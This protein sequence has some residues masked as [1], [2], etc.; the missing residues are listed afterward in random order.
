MTLRQSKHERDRVTKSGMGIRSDDIV[1]FPQHSV[2]AEGDMLIWNS[3]GAP[4]GRGYW[5]GTQ[6]FFGTDICKNYLRILDVSN[7]LAIVDAKIDTTAQ[8]IKNEIIGQAP[9][10]LDTLKEIADALGDPDNIAGNV[11][12]KLVNHDSQIL[13]LQAGKNITDVSVNMLHQQQL[14]HTN[15][16]A[17]LDQTVQNNQ[18]T[19]GN[20]IQLIDNQVTVNTTTV[21]AVQATTTT[22]QLLN[23]Q[24]VSQITDNSNNILN[25]ATN[26]TTNANNITLNDQH[27][28][29]ADLSFNTIFSQNTQRITDICGNLSRILSNDTDIA[30][31]QTTSSGNTTAINNSNI[32]INSNTLNITSNDSDINALSVRMNTAEGS[33]ITHTNLINTNLNTGNTNGG[34]ITTLTNLTT[35]HTNKIAILDASMARVDAIIEPK[36]NSNLAKINTNINTIATNATNI[37]NNSTNITNNTTSI[38]TN[39]NT[40]D[41][42]MNGTGAVGVL[43]TIKELADTIGDPNGIGSSVIT[44]LSQLDTSVTTLQN[45]KGSNDTDIATNATN[46]SSNL[47]LINTKE[48][49]ITNESLAM[50]KIQGLTTALNSKQATI[51]VN[52]LPQANVNGLILALTNKQD[53]I[54]DGGLSIVK[55]ANLETSLAA[56]Q[57]VILDNSLPQSKVFNLVASLGGKQPTVGP[58]DLLVSHVQGLQGLLDGKQ[59]LLVNESL[60][61][62]TITGLPGALAQKQTSLTAGSKITL[63]NTG[64]IDTVAATHLDELLDVKTGRNNAEFSN[65][66]LIGTTTTGTLLGAT[67][68]IGIG[69]LSLSTIN[70]GKNNTGIGINTLKTTT[71]KENCVAIGN[72]ALQHVNA[73]G[74]VAVGYQS[75]QN[76]LSGINNTFIGT[77]TDVTATYTN[78]NNATAIGY[79]AKVT[80]SNTVKLGNST[81]THVKTDGKYTAGAVTYTNVDGTTGQFLKTDGNGNTSWVG[82]PLVET[83]ANLD[84]SMNIVR[85]QADINT[86]NITTNT[87]AIAALVNADTS[88]LALITDISNS[89]NND[90]NFSATILAAITNKIDKTA[91]ATID[92]VKSFTSPI[93]GSL[94]GNATTATGFLTQTT[95]NGKAYHGQGNIILTAGDLG[96][97]YNNVATINSN[98]RARI[99][100]IESLATVEARKRSNVKA[101]GALM[102]DLSE[103]QDVTGVKKFVDGIEIPAGKQLTGHCS[104]ATVLTPGANINGHLFTGGDAITL[105]ATDLTGI[106]HAGSGAIITAAERTSYN[107]AVTR[108]DDLLDDNG[109]ILDS[110]TEISTALNNNP[111]FATTITNLANT[112]MAK[113][114]NVAESITGVKTFD[115]ELKANGGL[116]GNVTGNL[117]GNADT[118][119]GFATQTKINNKAYY[120]QGDITLTP[121]D[122]GIT[123]SGIATI[124][125]TERQKL[126][127]IATTVSDAITSTS[128][129]NNGAVLT[130]GAHAM[131]GKLTANNG[132]EIPTGKELTGLC[133]QATELAATVTIAG[134]NFNGTQNVTINA[135]DIADITSKGSGA[136]ITA[137]ERTQLT[138]NETDIQTN[139]TSINGH[140]S[141]LNTHTT[142]IG[143]LDSNSLKLTGNI[144]QSVNGLKTFTSGIEVPTGAGKVI[145]GNLEGNADTATA[146]GTANISICGVAFDGT[147]AITLSAD[148]LSDVTSSGSGAI[149]TTTERTKLTNIDTTHVKIADA[150]NITGVKTFDNGIIIPT[151]S[152]KQLTGNASTATQLKTAITIAGVSFDGSVNISIPSHGLSD[153]TNDTTYTHSGKIITDAERA[154]IAT[155]TTTIT[156]NKSSLDTTI[157]AIDTRTGDLESDSVLKDVAQTIASIKTFSEKIVAD[158]GIELGGNLH[159]T[160]NYP[161]AYTAVTHSNVGSGGE[162]QTVVVSELITALNNLSTNM[163]TLSAAVQALHNKKVLN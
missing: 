100:Q 87:N 153:I 26:I 13:F 73:N 127:D 123:Y 77:K 154:A 7:N 31:L 53:V 9:E 112:K 75:G 61:M 116:T 65:S 80:T 109:D 92:G 105:G 147:Q 134:K 151:G 36:T 88:T 133:S 62:A 107:N 119:T 136:I 129:L 83:V 90:A 5:S 126:T 156:T 135:T 122:L 131:A 104:T 11:V 38:T 78:L 56:K 86:T 159:A 144:A 93:V 115:H 121:T 84:A 155:N 30:A 45:E 85:P 64:T 76:I 128:L 48:P 117:T 111:N 12:N 113:D 4:D 35:S 47:T 69:H 140:T 14:T 98:E 33:L 125:G 139:L 108:L 82:L 18:I 41:T 94:T 143:T 66:L 145:K 114:G 15:Q 6:H 157:A 57:D 54:P 44:K 130:T 50:S 17:Q 42:L 24:H 148:K 89:L 161:T 29:K 46:I 91:N 110:I 19:Q 22:L 28:A 101:A 8:T 63:S 99:G 3:T 96:I 81:V 55:I 74:N 79:N 67:N 52:G 124:S 16:I 70:L 132:I 21:A 146:L 97:T 138:T 71:N 60:T 27:L 34:N 149:I 25:N 158:A 150:Q 20:Q 23:S 103:Q 142:Q 118:A 43:D 137:A 162:I 2:L 1:D 152:G 141:T 10:T 49:L 95:I 163:A 37:T 160:V 106:T 39:T 120:G 68:N 32:A 102:I 59:P 58:D 40:L 72:Y 51:G